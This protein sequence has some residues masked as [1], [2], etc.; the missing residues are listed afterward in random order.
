MASVIALRALVSAG[1][2]LGALDLVWIN[3]GLA[4]AL[5]DPPSS[6]TVA[7]ATPSEPAPTEAP[8]TPA[9][10]APVAPAPAIEATPDAIE[11][12][13]ERVY[14]T[15][16]SAVLGVRGR[17]TL[18]KLVELAGPT[19]VFS[20]EGHADYRGDEASNRTLSK[21]RA[22]SVQKELV[23]LGV[24]RGRIHVGFVGEGQASGDLWRDRRVEIQ[25]TGGT[26]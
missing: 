2:G 22:I 17:K 24:E 1:L 19:A 4:P 3:A 6:H 9:P 12:V 21:D 5:L 13:S 23:H 16:N 26:R 14:F 8:P 18:S 20:L 11:A 10:V 7:V 25:I 15:T